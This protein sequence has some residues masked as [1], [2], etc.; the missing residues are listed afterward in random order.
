[1]SE[2][3]VWESRR[4]NPKDALVF[5]FAPTIED[6][7]VN[8]ILGRRFLDPLPELEVIIDKEGQ[9]VP[10]DDLVIFKNRCLAH[11]QRLRK[12]LRD[13]G[14]DNIDYYPLRI[15]NS[16]TGEIYHSYKAANILDVIHCIDRENAV[17]DIDTENHHNI[18]YVNRLALIQERLGDALIFRLGELPWIVIVHRVVKEA[19]DAAGM[20]GVV[21][22]PA[23]GY[24]DY[25]GFAFN[26]PRNIIGTHDQDPDGPAD[27]MTSEMVAGPD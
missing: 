12:L 24:R 21:F 22:L 13:S 16:V 14:V 20:T 26:N 18:W 10:T 4:C 9:G 3:F 17:L 6:H 2:Y 7:G 8:F 25:P 27:G 11:S 15:R 1:M 23:E 19:V 5:E